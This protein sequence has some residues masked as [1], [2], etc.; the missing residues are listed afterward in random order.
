M[1]RIYAGVSDR[2]EQRSKPTQDWP[3]WELGA[4]IS[5]IPFRGTDFMHQFKMGSIPG[6]KDVLMLEL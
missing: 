3:D 2:S 5:K 1:T 4:R 6:I